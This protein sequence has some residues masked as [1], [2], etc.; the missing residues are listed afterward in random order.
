MREGKT[1]VMGWSW[2]QSHPSGGTLVG[3]L[4]R[5]AR[6]RVLVRGLSS[7]LLLL[8]QD[9]QECLRKP[10]DTL[11]PPWLPP[12][13]SLLLGQFGSEFSLELGAGPWHRNLPP[14]LLI[15]CQGPCVCVSYSP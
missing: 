3:G 13:D 2:L 15:Q 14:S 6:G 5:E 12:L 10:D 7:L 11:L 8:T 4:E 1:L 9:L